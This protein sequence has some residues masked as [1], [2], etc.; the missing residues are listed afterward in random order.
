MLTTKEDDLSFA[1][2]VET[3]H[4]RVDADAYEDIYVVGDVHG[5]LRE[6]EQLVET[7]GAD[8]ETLFVF[9]GDLV[10][11]GPDSSGVL[12]YVREHE[13]MV[14]VRGNNEQKLAEGRADC[15]GLTAR[16]DEYIESLP[17]AVSWAGALVVHGGIDP[18]VP[19]AEQT[20]DDLLTTRRVAVDGQRRQAYWFNRHRGPPQVFFGHTVLEEPIQTRSAVGLD[21]GC[22]YGGQL[23]AY[24]YSSGECVTLEPERAYQHRDDDDF[25][26]PQTA[27]RTQ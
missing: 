8:E 15:A 21:T 25:L 2:S 12:A 4:R 23:T 11:K 13:N 3:S 17:V 6:L 7:I 10:R 5:C 16:D 9:V 26:R 1:P 14:S 18:R 19:L 20:A 22:V 27:L 24:H